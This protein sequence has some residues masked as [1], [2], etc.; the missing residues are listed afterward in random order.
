M[1]KT[2]AEHINSDKQEKMVTLDTDFAGL[3]GGQTMYVSTPKVVNAAIRRI[4][5]GETRTIERFRREMA[6]KATCDGVC[7]M[8]TSIFIRISAQAAIDEMNA[9]KDPSEVTPFW[10]LLTAKDK[11]AKKLTIDASWIDLRREFESA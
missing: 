9:G 5:Y 11:I 7:P 6:R 2:A 4:P 10:R 8:S 1:A 3:K